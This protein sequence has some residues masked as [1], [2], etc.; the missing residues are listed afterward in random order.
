MSERRPSLD[1]AIDAALAGTVRRAAAEDLRARVMG[2]LG[3]PR[4]RSVVPGLAWPL[5]AAAAAAVVATVPRPARGPAR[6]SPMSLPPVT[7][8][9]PVARAAAPTAGSEPT[10]RSFPRRPFVP[11]RPGVERPALG[12]APLATKPTPLALARL[13]APPLEPIAPLP[14]RAEPIA[15][16]RSEPMVMAPLTEALADTPTQ[17]DKP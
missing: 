1:Q 2:R 3:R 12:F 10:A 11:E 9:A 5:A 17:E 6:P 15:P 16:L 13:E 14:E 4:W 7:R 8:P